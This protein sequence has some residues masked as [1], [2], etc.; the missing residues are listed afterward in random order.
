MAIEKLNIPGL[1][2]PQGYVHVA[3]ATGSR[4]IFLAGQVAQ[5]GDGN[6][7]GVGDLAAQMEQAL[8][9][10]AAGLQAAG[11]TF[12]DVVKTTLYVVDWDPSKMEQLIEGFVRAAAKVEGAG[13]APTTL[14]PVLALSQPDH[15]IEVD[16]TAIAE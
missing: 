12:A 5:D 16:V 8:L 9:N 14:I 11:A 7:V 2:E 6:T 3:V 15:L 1:P 13:P 4:Q 10:V